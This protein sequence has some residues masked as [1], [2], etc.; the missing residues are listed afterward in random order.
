M[1]E[2]THLRR[3]QQRLQ[4][5]LADENDLQQLLF[6]GFE[7]REDANLLEHRQRQ[8]LCLVDD[9][10]RARLEGDERQQEVVQRVDELLLGD[11]GEPAGL[12]LLA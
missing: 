2:L 3:P 8:V 11:P 9:E 1:I 10:H 6:I 7:I 12:P 4:I 5:Q